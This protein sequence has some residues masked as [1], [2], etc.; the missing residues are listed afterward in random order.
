MLVFGLCVAFYDEVW[1]VG[2]NNLYPLTYILTD[3]VWA[4][5]VDQVPYSILL[6]H[7]YAQTYNST[8]FV[9]TW[10]VTGEP[11]SNNNNYANVAF[12]IDVAAGGQ[13]TIDWGDDRGSTSIYDESGRVSHFYRNSDPTTDKSATIIISGD[14]ERFYFDYV[15][16]F[17]VDGSPQLLLSIDQWG[18]TKWTNMRDMFKGAVN[19]QY[20]ATDVPDLTYPPKSVHSMFYEANAFNGDLSNWDVSLMTNLRY[21]F[22]KTP[23]FTG[24]LSNWNVSSVTDMTYMFS[25]ADNFNSDISRWDVSNVKRMTQMFQSAQVFNSDISRWDVSNVTN[26]YG[27]FIDATSFNSN[28]S[29]WNVSSVTDMSRMFSYA[30]SFNSNLSTWNVS[31]VTY[32]N[33]MFGNASSFNHNQRSWFINLNDTS[34]GNGE[35]LVTDI[36]TSVGFDADIDNYS[37]TGTDADAFTIRHGQLFLTSTSNYSSKSGYSITITANTTSVGSL[38]LNVD[39]SRSIYVSVKSTA[40]APTITSITRHNPTTEI[41]DS[42]TLVYKVKFNKAVTNVNLSDFTLSSS[43]TGGVGPFTQTNSDLIEIPS[44]LPITDTISMFSP[45][46]VS[47]VS[48]AVDITHPYV[49]QLAVDLIAPDGTTRTLHSRSGNSAGEIYQTYTPNFR[50]TDISGNWTLNIRDHDGN[51][52]NGGVLHN[53]TLTIYSNNANSDNNSITSISGSGSQY[54][55]TVSAS[56]DGTYNLDL[57][58]NSGIKDTGNHLLTNIIPTGT[59]QT[60][61]VN[62]ALDNTAPTLTSIERYNPAA[63][64]TT[65]SQ[66]LV[67]EVTFS[68]AV[69]GVTQSDFVLSSDSTGAANPVTSI[70]GSGSQYFVTV[71]ASSDGTYNLDLVQNHG[72]EDSAD[73]PLT[74]TATT[75]V[76]QTY[77]VNTVPADT[78]APTLTSIERYNPVAATTDSQTLVYEVTFS[79]AVTGVTQSDFV[80]SSDSTGAANPVTSISGSGSQYFVTVSA[81]SDGTYNLDLVQNH[82]IEDSAD[83]PL[84]DTATTGVDHTYTVNTVPADTTAPTLTSIE[85]YNPAA[86][87]TTDSQTLVYEV[88]FSEAVTGVTQSDF[89]LSSDS[90]GGSDPGTGTGQFT[91]T[92]SPSTIIAGNQ[93][94]IDTIAVSNSGNV[95]SVS[96]NLNITHTYIGDLKVDLVAPDGTTKTLHNSSGGSSDDIVATYTPNFNGTSISGTWTL[97]INDN[98][99]SADDGVLNSWTLTINYGDTTDVPSPVTSIS[100]SGSQY[101]VTVSASSDGTYNLDLVQNHGIEDSADNPLTDTATTGVDQT[102]TVNTVPADT[103]APTLTSIERYNPAAAATTDSQTLVY[104]VTF[105]EAV[106]GVTQ[107]DFVLSSDST[108]GPDTDTGQFTQTNSPSTAITGA[109]DVT[110]TIAVSNSGNVTSVSVNLNITHTYI[111]DL[112][113]DLVAPDGTTKTLHNRS[114]G[115]SDD[116]VA[117]YTP[118]FNGTSISGTWTLK[119][120]DDYPSADDGVLNSWTLTIN[121]GDPTDIHN[122]I[123][124]ISGSGSQY[125][126]TVSASS[127]GT[128]NLDLVQNHGIEDSADNPLTDTATT[129]VDHTYTVNTV[130]AD[131]TAPTLTSI[132]RY[133]PVAATTDSQTLVYE[134]TFSEAVTGV[135]QSDFVLSSD[136]T[137]AANPVTSISGSGSQYFVTVSA[138]SDGTYNLDLVQNHG[139]E[140]SADNPLT[141]TA[142]TGVDHTYTVN[143]VPADT[144]APTLTSIERYNPAAAATTDSQT[145]VY[146]VTFSEAVTG[147]TQSDFVLSSDSTGGSDPGTG[148][149]QFTQTESPSTIIAGNQDIIDT[150][151]VSN[152]GNVTSVSVNLNI[153]HTYIG[154]LKVDLVAPDGTTKT[155]HNSSGGS[156]DDIVAT[157]TPNFNGTSISGTWTLKI[158]DNFPSAD[159]GVL[160]SWTLTI[161]YGDTTDVPSPVTSISGS[162]SQYFVTVSASSDGTYN[163]DLVQNHGI[164]D[165]AD[166]PLTDTATT[167][168]DHTYTVNTVPADTTAPTLTSIERYNPA[169]A[170]T[171]DS[172]TLVYEVTFSEAVTGVTQS[173]FVLSSDSTGGSD[174]GTGTGQFT[175]TESP[176]TIIA[177]NQDIIDTIAVSNSGNVT[178]VSVNLNITHTYIGDLKVDLVAP[179]GTTKTLHNS[180]GGSSDDIVA[181]YTPNFNGTSISG[182]WTLKINDNF[183]SADDGVLN[184]W[185]LTINYGDTTDVPSPVTSISGS[186]SQYFVTV[187]ASSDGT[188]NLDLVQNHGIE[189]SADNPLT[190]TATT[191]VDQTYTVNTV[192]ADTTAPT[193]TSIERYNPVAA[194]TDSQTLVYEVTFSEAVTGV[195]QSD[196][197]L[198]SDSTG[199]ANP[200]TSISGSGSQYFVTVSASSDG[201]YNLD[202]VQ[203]HGIEDSADNPLTDTATTGVDQTYTVNTVPADTTAPTLTSIERYNPAA[204]ATTDS[205]TL[206]YEVTFSEAVT[207]VTQ[208]DFVLSSD[209]TGGPDTDTGQFTQ[210]NSPST[211]ITG[212]QDVT[213]TIAVSNSGNVTSVSVNLNITHTYIGDLKVDLVAPDGTTKTL[214]NRSGGSSDDIVATYTPSFNG[215]SISGTWTLKINDDYPSADDGVLNSWTLTIN[216]GD[217]TDIHNPITS[218]SGSG[219]QY[220]VTVSASSDGTYNLDLVQNHGIE[221]SADNPLTDTAT[222]GVDHTYTVN[223]VPADTTAPTLTSIERYNPVAATTDSQTL[224]YEVTFSEAVTGVTQSD[225]VLSSDSTGAANPV[226]SISGSGSQYFVTVSASS[227]GTYNLDL[228]QNHGIEDSADNPLTDTATTGVDQTYT[229]NTVPADTTAPTLTSIERYNPAA[230]ATTD[231]QTLVYEVTFSEA[232]TGVTQSDFV[233]SSD[234]TGGSDPGTGTGQFTQTESPSTIIAGNQ[235]IIDT[236]AVSN[237]GNVTSVSVNLNIT[238]TYIGDLKV[239]LVAPDGTTKTLHNSSGGSSDDIVATYTPNF[240]G[241]SISGTWT[242]KI[243]DNFPSADDGVLNSWT[244]TINYGDTTDVPSPVTSISG[245][246]SQYFVTVSASSDGTYNLD[247]V[248]NHGIEDSADNPLTDTATTGVDQ[249]YTVNTVP[250][251]TTAPTLTSIE[252][253]NPVAATTDSQTL[254]YEVTFSEAVTGVTQSDFVLSSDSTGGSDPG[255]GTG[256]FT[257]TESPSTIIAGNQDIIDTIAVSNSGNVTSVSVNLNITHTYIGDLKVDLVAPDGTTKT[258]HNS[259]GGSSDDIVATYTPNFNGTSISGTWTLK[260]NDNFPSADDGVLNSWTLTINYGDT[261]DVP[262]PVTSISGSGSQYFVTVSAS[263]DGTYN[264]D[265]VQNHGIEDSA[266]NPLTDTAT[267]GVDQTYTVNTVPADTTAPTLTSIERYNPVAATTDSQTLVYEVTFSEAVTGVTQSDF[268][269]SSDSTGAANPVTSISGSGSQYFVTVSASSDGTYNLDLVQNHGIEDSADNPLTDTATTGVDHTYTVN[270]VPADTTAPT[271]TSIE[272]YNPVAATTDSQTLVYEVTFSEA[273]TG[274]TQSEFVLSSD[275]T[276]A[277]NPVTSISGSGSQYFVTVSASSDG[278]YNLDL[279]QNHGIEDS[280]DNPLTDTATT[281]VDQTYT[282]NTVPADTTAP[283]LTSIE[284]YN[285]VAAT[286]DSQTLVYEVTFSE[287]VTG[288]TQSDFVLSSDST[289]G[290]DP[291]T[292]TGQFTQTESPST[293]IAGNQDII[294]TIAVSNSGNVTSV[295]VNLN[296]THTYIGDLK[297]DL[298]APDGTTKTL[299]NRSGGSSDDIVATY[300]PNF[301]GTSISGTWTLKINDNY[302][303]EDYGVLNSWT[304]TINY[305]DTTDVPSPV[306]SISGSGSQYFVTVSAS[307]DG[308][309]NLDLVQ[310]HGIEDSADNPLTDTATTGVDHTYTVNTDN[311]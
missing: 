149:G 246:G 220:F 156:S 30:T 21:M 267:T 154:D 134:V 238:H 28:L 124:S 235:D 100:G 294:D 25:S 56:G 126:V 196:F 18:D 210:T 144:T 217:P 117:T 219:S 54:F 257:Q 41:T 50:G 182:T 310:N 178:S 301:N 36:Y 230:A 227:D 112:K 263:S 6:P 268:V 83:N 185:T 218:I 35:T 176:S 111:S 145:L 214:H 298:V 270:T 82:G 52:Y 209:S 163:L 200:V 173:D 311:T 260:I 90:T 157:Y 42:Q 101:F 309:Y 137:G 166:N 250:A 77:T 123:T 162:G 247:L 211:A 59:D 289:G 69:T 179:D 85:R 189:D 271:L 104:E 120:N 264:L 70:S 76:D 224:V 296:I 49:G 151:A 147:V 37:I 78:T 75:G 190:D 17:T 13:V 46:T 15:G 8:V 278:T 148:T 7:V 243:N 102:Y 91:Q 170:A 119:I 229:V 86:A 38:S 105:S 1:E 92:E 168:V 293:I 143:T 266:D 302:L 161:N 158:N 121:H 248:Q 304:L 277:A 239:D 27:M 22:Y 216:H 233:L 125:F 221:D 12:N 300:T 141:D 97:K 53:W 183:P 67:Y 276:G 236:I 181:T 44:Y 32:M 285:P 184:S 292:G 109:Q 169:A 228:V 116:I 152:S 2:A 10:D 284:R 222:T 287:A 223:T 74:D 71:S 31:S 131:T 108:G 204:A 139:I 255:T 303:Y 39:P 87:A 93:D 159:D 167:G 132:E 273:V 68:E 4:D 47:S 305:G 203:N 256:Q 245:S 138:S 133:N 153:T 269:L 60:Y 99:P 150:I 130:P 19:M 136:S 3:H 88:T 244:L 291:G 84:T 192:P 24:N 201:T 265:L 232:V 128:Y 234:S 208:S 114:G 79:E 23:S 171:T 283:T 127:D 180:S 122:P 186:G 275:S 306:T 177:G 249:T 281:G 272:R 241:T 254:V 140:D 231:S 187:S 199:A 191:G 198:S 242:L 212:A 146:E 29:T 64:A 115:S 188:Y 14:L 129:G 288:V 58:S 165:S 251:D 26:M 61:I 103:T 20:R 51:S 113:V 258:L 89:V 160:N 34:I 262:S 96:V 73:N 45:K 142:T 63:A 297:V 215:T 240:N 72:I 252:R 261:T 207:G 290:S 205:Q 33:D 98:F 94:I 308:T 43:S 5:L 280:A 213:D 62:T 164:E 286:T 81:S 40:E 135:T 118:S 57:V 194:T 299:H 282:V 11:V 107:S 9:T 55:V 155:L 279:V 253:Y 307:S 274:V 174:P 66:T 65:D 193:L 197:V 16:V 172:Q 226:T 225:F 48:V 95:T 80:L 106:T 195:T 202:L 237:S 206:V 295:S 259:S 110:D 175:Q